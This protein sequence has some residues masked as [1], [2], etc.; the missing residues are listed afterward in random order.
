MDSVELEAVEE[1]SERQLKSRSGGYSLTF[2]ISY[3]LMCCR[4]LNLWLASLYPAV[5]AAFILLGQLGLMQS[6]MHLQPGEAFERRKVILK[7]LCF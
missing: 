3:W 5:L 6:K 1:Q 7:L 2:V 4:K